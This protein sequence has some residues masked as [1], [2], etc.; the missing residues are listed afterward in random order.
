MSRND[1]PLK[2][3]RKQQHF[4]KKEKSARSEFFT[5]ETAHTE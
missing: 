3:V 2:N 5:A 4:E 1:Q